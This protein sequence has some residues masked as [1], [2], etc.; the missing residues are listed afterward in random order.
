M[1]H[2]GVWTFLAVLACC[3]RATAQSDKNTHAKGSEKSKPNA[4]VTSLNIH[5]DFAVKSD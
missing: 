1:N 2:A 4:L 3:R 5:V